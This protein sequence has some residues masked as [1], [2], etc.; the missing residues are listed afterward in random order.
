VSEACVY[1]SHNY[2]LWDEFRRYFDTGVFH[3]EEKWILQEFGSAQ[4]EG[5]R[6]VRSELSMAMKAPWRKAMVLLLEISA[7]TFLKY[8]G[9][10]TGKQ[11]AFLPLL[12]KRKLGFFKPYWD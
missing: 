4:G 3:K 5:Y 7:R 2:T 6:F 10:Q 9:Y 8:L 1:H 11:H 12:I